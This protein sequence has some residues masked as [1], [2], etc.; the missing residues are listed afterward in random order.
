VDAAIDIEI[1]GGTPAPNK[2]IHPDLPADGDASVRWEGEVRADAAGDHL[3]TTYSN[4]G[5]RFTLDGRVLIDHW[6][7]G[8]LPWSDVARVRLEAGKRYTLTLEWRKDQGVETMRLRWKTPAPSADTSLWSEVGDGVDYYLVYG[9]SIDQVV[10]GYRRLTGQ[11]PMMPRGA[12]GL[13]Q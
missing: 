12:F 10:A 13:W 7:Q 9:P 8:W 2:R 11:A 5:I 1:P 3:F 4:A 6:R